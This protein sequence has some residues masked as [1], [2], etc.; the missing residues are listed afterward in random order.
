[1]ET[2]Q[3]YLKYLAYTN[4]MAEHVS[5]QATEAKSLSESEFAELWRSLQTKEE[6]THRFLAGFVADVSQSSQVI[7]V[8]KRGFGGAAA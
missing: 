2:D 4:E 1:M 6:W 7:E 3:I 8:N 5:S